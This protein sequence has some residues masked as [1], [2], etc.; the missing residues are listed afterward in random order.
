V[1]SP[2]ST[3]RLAVIS[4]AAATAALVGIAAPTGAHA[5]NG[6]FVY[7][8]AKG[9]QQSIPFPEENK[10]YS[11]KGATGAA[12]YTAGDAYV[13][14]DDHCTIGKDAGNIPRFQNTMVGF[15]SVVLRTS[16]Q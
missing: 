13:Y 6:V 10:C 5:A 2:R 4:A 8:D 11:T 9:G 16:S 12:N 14:T 7:A 1:S 15:N 3:G